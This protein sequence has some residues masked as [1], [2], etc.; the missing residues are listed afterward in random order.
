VRTDTDTFTA[1]DTLIKVDRNM[2]FVTTVIAEVCW[3][4]PETFI[5]VDTLFGVYFD[6]VG[7]LFHVL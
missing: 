6:D 7:E 1:S 5:A 3:T 2:P 4:R